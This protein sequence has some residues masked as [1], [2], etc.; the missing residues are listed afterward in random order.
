MTTVK[1]EVIQLHDDILK[2]CLAIDAVTVKVNTVDMDLDL[3]QE[4]I[5]LPGLFT[6]KDYRPYQIFIYTEKGSAALRD[7]LKGKEDILNSFDLEHDEVV[8]I[9]QDIRDAKRSKRQ[10]A[11]A[12]MVAVGGDGSGTH[13]SSVAGGAPTEKGLSEEGKVALFER[14]RESLISG[15]LQPDVAEKAART[16][17]ASATSTLVKR[18][19]AARTE[20]KVASDLPDAETRTKIIKKVLVKPNKGE[21]HRPYVASYYQLPKPVRGNKVVVVYKRLNQYSKIPVLDAAYIRKVG[22]NRLRVEHYSGN[23]DMIPRDTRKISGVII[24]QANSYEDCYAFIRNACNG[25]E[26]NFSVVSS[27]KSATGLKVKFTSAS[28]RCERLR[29]TPKPV[30]MTRLPRRAGG[31]QALFVANQIW[32]SKPVLSEPVVETA[33]APRKGKKVDRR[34]PLPDSSDHTEDDDQ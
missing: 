11:D 2:V 6:L 30:P 21:G 31:L 26:V 29:F 28:I 17:V 22:L 27:S 14:T 16:A 8:K 4:T 24:T 1:L 7:Q 23:L 9:N 10:G 34:R 13:T 15:G 32:N 25:E 5:T 18:P 20:A 3:S 33:A 12:P 19:V